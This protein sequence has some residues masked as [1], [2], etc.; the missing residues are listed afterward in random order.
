[1]HLLLEK[2]ANIEAKNKKGKT[3]LI[4]ASCNG[5]TTMVQLLLAS[6]ARKE[7][8]DN[9]GKTALDWAEENVRT[10]VVALLKE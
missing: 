7:T 8:M 3:A 10:A 9:Y 2:G 4:W 5:H 1:M 6:G